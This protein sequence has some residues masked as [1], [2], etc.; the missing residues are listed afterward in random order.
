MARLNSFR[1]LEHSRERFMEK[2]KVFTRTI[3][4]CGG[5]GC[6]A[7]KSPVVIEAVRKELDGHK[8]ENSVR[9]CTTGCHGFC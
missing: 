8:L 7:S 9:L 2:R 1:E 3:M 4:I 6:Q 5:T